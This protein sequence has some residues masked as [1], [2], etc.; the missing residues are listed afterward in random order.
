MKFL[1]FGVSSEIFWTIFFSKNSITN[2]RR[3]KKAYYCKTAHSSFYSEYKGGDDFSTDNFC[4]FI[5]LFQRNST[6]SIGLK[7]FLNLFD[8][9]AVPTSK[10]YCSSYFFFIIFICTF[11]Y[12]SRMFEIWPTRFIEK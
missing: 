9:V 3:K 12:F 11:L 2:I 4:W 8:D 1:I 6:L 10:I 5:I 7:G